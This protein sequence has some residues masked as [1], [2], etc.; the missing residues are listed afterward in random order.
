[1]DRS[2]AQYQL[3]NLGRINVVLGKNGSGKST[4]LKIVE[5]NL[6]TEGEKRYVTPE[7][8]GTLTYEAGIDHNLTTDANWLRSSRRVNQ[9]VQFRQ[10]SMAQFRRLELAVLRGD[11]GKK[12]ADFAP[13]VALLNTLLDNVEIERNTTTFDI[14]SLRDGGRSIVAAGDISSGESE[15]ISLG[16]EA[17][18][19]AEELDQEKENY[20]ILDEPDVHLHPDLQS[21][22]MEFLV[23]LV[24]DYKFNVLLATHS[25]A[26]LG[27]L[28]D[29]PGTRVAFIQSGETEL[30]FEEVTEVHKRVLPVFGAHP[31]S[32]VFNEAPVLIVEGEDDER[33]WQQAV[34]TSSGA[35]R[36]YPVA[37]QDGVS[38]MSVYEQ[39]VRR[40]I[41]AVYDQAVGYSLRDRDDTEGE[42][43]DEP[44]VKRMKLGCRAAE[45][46]ILSDDVLNSMSITWEEAKS[47]IED[48][49]SANA[50]RPRFN[51][52]KAFRDCGFDRKAADLK[53]IR[54]V[55]VGVILGSNKSWEV[56]AGQAI[57]RLAAK[58]ASINPTPDSLQDYLGPKTV[59]NLLI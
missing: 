44:P 16:I 27:A 33:V 32:N 22:L 12:V 55:L 25:T 31:L 46:L 5:Q 19:Y 49:L 30:D 13:Y 18:A 28:S 53:D 14:Y 37:C 58:G 47:R 40:I 24:D 23:S 39:E 54:N 29:V 6:E 34:R 35:L 52:M 9:F 45:N 21:R 57:G 59:G 36:V 3:K 10:Q 51:E 20:L 15:L 11:E 4:L 43:A 38:G 56:L 41:A 50:D 2:A 17:L 1:M 7:R 26:L 48:W 8:G 42:I